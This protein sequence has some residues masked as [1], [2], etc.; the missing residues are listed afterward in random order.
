[1]ACRAAMAV[2]AVGFTISGTLCF[3]WGAWGCCGVYAPGPANRPQC[4]CEGIPTVHTGHSIGISA[5]TRSCVGNVYQSGSTIWL[6]Q[7]DC[8][9]IF[10]GIYVE[11]NLYVHSIS[12]CTFSKKSHLVQRWCLAGKQC[13]QSQALCQRQQP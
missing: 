7:Q 8:K 10:A 13:G 3:L 11:K 2:A 12:V 5:S 4:P 6:E 9:I 1:M